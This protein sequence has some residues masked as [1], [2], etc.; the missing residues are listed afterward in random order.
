MKTL[1]AVVALLGASPLTAL[2]ALSPTEHR[3]VAS[4]VKHHDED[5]ALLEKLVEVNSG[6]LNLAGVTRVADM[7][8]PEFEALGLH[9]RWIPMTEMGRAGHLEAFHHAAGRRTKRILLIAH[10]DTVFDADSPFQ[11]FERRGNIA[12]GPGTNDIKGGVVVI[13]AALRALKDAGVLDR[14]DVTVYLSGDEEDPGS[15]LEAARRDL[16]AAGKAS[17]VALDFEAMVRNGN[18]D[19]IHI[20]RRSD[21][22]WKLTTSGTAGHSSGVG[23]AGGYGAN[24]ELARIVDE[25]RRTLPEPNLTFNVGLI[26]GGTTVELA[27]SETRATT[28]GKDN[29]IAAQAVATGDIRTLSDEQTARIEQAMRDIVA[30]HLPGT[31]ARIEFIAGYPAMAPTPANHRLF[32][33]LNGVN[34]DL[35]LAPLEEGDPAKRG[36]G[37]ISFVAKDVPGLVGMGVA[38]EGSHAIG[39]TADL[40]SLD[41]QAERTAILIERL[42]R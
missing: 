20:G 36:A 37:D 32:A 6:T 2:A 31:D 7:L 27:Q 28:A 30:K 40:T 24:Y 14:A 38:G 22:A 42:S 12:E 11:H 18:H 26:A 13:I 29:I 39:E 4:V 19:T 1:L 9:V 3:I 15:P 21:N 41:P 8:R 25:F 5:V 35:G 10:L 17:D 34:A 16:I 33:D 23:L